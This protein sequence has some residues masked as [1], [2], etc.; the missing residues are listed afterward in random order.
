MMP[1]TAV[2][3]TGEAHRLL[4][5]TDGV[6]DARTAEDRMFG[7]ARLGDFVIRHSAEGLPAPETLRRLNR[8]IVDYQQGRVRDDATVV[9]L[10]WMPRHPDAQL[11]A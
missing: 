11:T 6:T 8:T 2:Q 7:L 3:S 9:L 5:Y 4:L 1:G 10:E